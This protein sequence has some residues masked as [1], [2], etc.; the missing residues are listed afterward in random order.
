VV[1]NKGRR[2]FFCTAVLVSIARLQTSV[3]GSLRHRPGRLPRPSGEWPQL[4]RRSSNVEPGPMGR[5]C[6][7]LLRRSA[8]RKA[9][10]YGASFGGMVALAY[11]I[12]S[13]PGGEQ[14]SNAWV[15]RTLAVSYARLGERVAAV[16]AL[17]ALWRA[18]PDLTISQVSAHIVQDRSWMKS[19]IAALT[20]TGRSS[21]V[22]WPQPSKMT[23]SRSWDAYFGKSAM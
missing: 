14:P 15:N 23:T 4:G 6:K 20:S 7:S 11:G 5:R 21:W 9:H 10:L 19:I 17:D 13:T 1:F 22:M 3:F 8:G 18:L 12:P 16:D 2:S